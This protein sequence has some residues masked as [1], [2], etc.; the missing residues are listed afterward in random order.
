MIV[1]YTYQE[2]NEIIFVS[3][4]TQFM[5]S[6]ISIANIYDFTLIRFT[7]LHIPLSF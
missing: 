3:S 4:N 2:I 5:V 6:V 1:F 7:L